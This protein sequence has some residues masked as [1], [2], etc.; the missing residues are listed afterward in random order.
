MEGDLLL[1]SAELRKF[2]VSDI[3]NGQSTSLLLGD[4]DNQIRYNYGHPIK[5]ASS[6]GIKFTCLA[7]EVC[8]LG[9]NSSANLFMNNNYIT[10]LR[11][12]DRPL[13]ADTFQYWK[14]ISVVLDSLLV[15][16]Q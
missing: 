2:G 7:G 8:Q 15:Q 14:P 4:V 13:T 1:N 10:A 5:L 12:P 3:T 9:K 16:V 6:H 11:D